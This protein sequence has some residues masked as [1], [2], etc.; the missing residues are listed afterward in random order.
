MRREAERPGGSTPCRSY[1]SCGQQVHRQQKAFSMS[2]LSVFLKC[3]RQMAHL[4]IKGSNTNRREERFRVLRSPRNDKF[5]TCR[6]PA[7][8]A[9]LIKNIITITIAIILITQYYSLVKQWR[10]ISESTQ[11]RAAF[12]GVCN[13]RGSFISCPPSG[14]MFAF[15]GYDSKSCVDPNPEWSNVCIC[16]V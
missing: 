15:V 9:V 11:P 14:P 8:S 13:W 5:A 12:V 16:W 6:T 1:R 3:G 2:W 10:N 7:T 4:Y